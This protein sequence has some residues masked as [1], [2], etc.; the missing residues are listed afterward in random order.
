MR[1]VKDDW[2]VGT[3]TEADEEEENGDLRQI[4][5]LLAGGRWML[6]EK[7]EGRRKGRLRMA[8]GPSVQVNT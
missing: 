3:G 4:M 1:K 2:D 6:T 8:Y 5:D 7:N